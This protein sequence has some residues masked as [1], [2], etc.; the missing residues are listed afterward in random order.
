MVRATASDDVLGSNKDLIASFLRPMINPA[1][2]L[3]EARGNNLLSELALFNKTYVSN[4]VLALL[5][6]R[7][8]NFNTP[9]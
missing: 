6:Y 7:P 3:I 5:L 9:I 8:Q 1:S 4:R 2:G